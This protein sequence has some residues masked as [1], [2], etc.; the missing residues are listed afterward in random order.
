MF[1]RVVPNRIESTASM[2]FNLG[3]RFMT[4]RSEKLDTPSRV[5]VYVRDPEKS[6]IKPVVC[7]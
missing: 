3:R 2:G 6:F 1:D 7:R 4:A 5:N